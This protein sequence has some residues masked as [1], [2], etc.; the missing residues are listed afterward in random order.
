MLVSMACFM[1]LYIFFRTIKYRYIDPGYTDLY[2]FL[3]Y[4]YY[5]P[6]IFVPLVSFMTACT[7]GKPE[8]E[9]LSK[10]WILP[11]VAGGVLAVGILTNNLHQ[12]AFRFENGGSGYSYGI[13]FY[14]VTVWIYSFLLASILMLWHKCKVASIKR[15]V[16]LPFIWLPIGTV[17]V[18]LLMC[19]SV[20]G[21]PSLFEL[22]EIHCFI[23]A[24]MWESCIH[25]GLIPCNAGYS[26]Y[27]SGSSLSAQIADNN[28]RIVFS[29]KKAV[30]V[31]EEQMQQSKIKPVFISENMLL[32]S[33]AVCGGNIFWTEDLTAVNEMN[34]ELLE[35]GER[36]CEESDLLR[37]ENEIKEQ[38]ARIAEQNRLYDSIATL[39]KPQLDK[40]ARLLESEQD[41]KRK[42][43]LVCVLNCYVK[44]RA[45]LALLADGCKYIDARELY[46]SVRESAEY[47]KLCG[48]SSYVY[49]SGDCAALSE[50]VLLAFDI[51]QSLIEADLPALTAVMADIFTEEG[52]ILMMLTFDTAAKPSLCREYQSKLELFGGR[53]DITQ[54]DETVFVK[55]FMPK[56]GDGK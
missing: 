30:A 49:F 10:A 14:V 28:N 21:I 41:F 35:I 15:R 13:L 37:A 2:N 34:K 47:I 46:L 45:N 53:M 36:L 43:S 54:E 8:D 22:P 40:I 20:T 23:V 11:F 16:W 19:K 52:S 7:V 29:S 4:G 33:D 27:F 24:A 3:W 55:L 44:R 18:I 32:H 56:G 17:L 25:I 5:V 26:E 12:L 39:V 42:M 9:K 38:K 50:H 51:W 48:V 1:L 31:T 6:Q